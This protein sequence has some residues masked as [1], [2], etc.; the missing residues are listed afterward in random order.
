MSGR[1]PHWFEPVADHLGRRLPPLLVHEGHR[2][3]GRLPRRRGRARLRAAVCSTWAVG[4]GA[5]FVRSRSARSRWSASTSRGGSCRWRRS[6]R[7]APTRKPTLATCRCVP[8]ASTLAIS[9]CQGAFGLLGGPG[10][11]VDEDLD[12][13]REMIAA[14]RPG[15]RIVLSAFSSYFQ[16]RHLD[17]AAPVRRGRGRAARAHRGARRGRPSD[18]GRAVDDVLHAP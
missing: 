2:A 11:G 9:L 15:G 5:T 1:E 12:V 8:T 18:P 17:D 14:V 10:S 4:R 3:G 6:R 7:G 13:L 16:V